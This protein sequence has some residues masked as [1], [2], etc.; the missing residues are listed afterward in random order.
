MVP[1]LDWILTD[2]GWKT[3]LEVNSQGDGDRATNSGTSVRTF[4]EPGFASNNWR[5]SDEI[6]S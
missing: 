5:K 6:T 1:S 4:S 2:N 3:G